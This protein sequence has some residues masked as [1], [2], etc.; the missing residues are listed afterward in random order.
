ML[1]R[2]PTGFTADLLTHEPIKMHEHLAPIQPYYLKELAR[3]YGNIQ[4]D[5]MKGWID[6]IPDMPNMDDGKKM[7]DVK[8]VTRIF[9]HLGRPYTK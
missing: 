2:I 1:T 8:Q 3:L 4:P 6:K 9:E 7:Y 5:T